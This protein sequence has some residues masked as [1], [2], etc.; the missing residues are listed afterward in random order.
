[1][2][3][4]IAV[5]NEQE[6][7]LEKALA[8]FRV[9]SEKGVVPPNVEPGHRDGWGVAAYKEEKIFLDKN[10]RPASEDPNFEIAARRIVENTP[11]LVLGHLRKAS[12]GSVKM[13]NT[14]PYQ[15][16][17]YVFCHN[18]KVSNYGELELK[19]EYAKLRKG[20][21]D[22]EVIFLFLVQAITERG[23]LIG[24]FTEV[25]RR[26]RTMDYTAVNLLFSDGKTLIAMKE[27]N[28]GNETV[29]SMNLC[30]SYYTLFEGKDASGTTKFVS[31]E[32]LDVPDISWI[33]IPNHGIVVIDVATGVERGV[34]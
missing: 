18:G 10:P 22:S 24:A 11:R 2:C 9:L 1:M 7:I 25:A 19:P 21:A 8:D 13:E 17:S 20:D 31:S 34:Q 4:L 26:L 32:P 5:V 23:D 28:E 33:G 27:A 16:D 30:D 14:Q 3:R 12:V 29:K 15:F 6:D